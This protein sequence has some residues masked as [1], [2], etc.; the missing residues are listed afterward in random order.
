METDVN[1][2]LI[3]AIQGKL[4]YML[5]MQPLFLVVKKRTMMKVIS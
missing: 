2:S 1:F 4:A 3:K 5:D